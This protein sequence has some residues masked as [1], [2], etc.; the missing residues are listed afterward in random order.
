MVRSANTGISGLIDPYG[1]VLET[2]PLSHSG[3]RDVPLPAALV[4]LTPYAR[5]GDL[6]LILQLMIAGLVAALL[7]FF[8]L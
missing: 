1:R 5:F 7:S 4:V 2:I 3:V 6:V 8:V